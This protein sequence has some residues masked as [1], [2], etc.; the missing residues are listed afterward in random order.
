MVSP[1]LLALGVIVPTLVVTRGVRHITR[2]IED[3]TKAAQAMAQGEF[4]QKIVART[5]DEIEALAGQFNLMAA[6]IQ[7]SYGTLEQRVA[8]R[9]NEL[10]ALTKQFAILNAISAS[11]NE[12]LDLEET[13]NRVLD[14]TMGLLN[15]EVGEIRLLD[16]ESDELI[17]GAQRGMSPE[18][19]RRAERQPVTDILPSAAANQPIIIED[20]L[21]HPAY[22]LPR[23]EGLR[24]LAIFPLRARERLLGVLCL[25]TRRGPRP[26]A[27]SERELLRS[28]SDQA[29]VAIENAQLYVETRRR[30]DEIET[31]FAVQQA[32]TSRLDP[33]SVLQLIADEARRLTLA[34]GAFVFMLERDELCL[35]VISGEQAFDIAV[36]FRMPM[37]QSVTGVAL[38]SGQILRLA[39][40][41]QDPRTNQDLVRR[42]KAHSLVIVPLVSGPRIIGSISVVNKTTGPFTGD[43]ERVLSMLASSAI[44]GLENARLYQEEQDRRYEAEQRRQ[45]AEGLRDILTVLNSSRPLNEIL[46]YIVAQGTRLLGSEAVALFR[47]QDKNGGVLKPQAVLGLPPEYLTLVEIPVGEAIVG[48]VVQQIKPLAVPDIT[49]IPPVGTDSLQQDPEQWPLLAETTSRFRAMLGVPLVIKNEVYG[50]IML[51]YTQP[52][53]FTDEEIGLAVSFADQVA[54][55]I[56]NARLFDQAEQ[57]AILEERQ[58]LA[59]EL[60]DSVTQALYGVTMFAEAAARLLGAGKIELATDH[61]N[62]LRGTAQEA[63]QEMRLLLFELRPPVLEE[64]GLIAA[65]QTRLEAVERRSGLATELT[66]EGDEELPVPPKIEE[67][68]YRIAQEALNNALKHAQARRISIYLNLDPQKITLEIADDGQGFDPVKVRDHGGLGL[69]GMAERV[70]QLGACLT[71]SSQPGQG[72]KIKVEVQ[73]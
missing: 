35:S 62:E 28:V 4:N 21:T 32:I 59:R 26:V 5:G 57:A 20:L 73:P 15:L 30:V 1:L 12:S 13:L 65:L 54:L 27:R 55:A 11:V 53:E 39:D 68:L 8:A 24:A 46:D 7:E 9:T 6:Q 70:N 42:L 14:E 2:P 63:L 16:E 56:E 18:F 72:A 38:Q 29:S 41:G 10:A 22:S 40:A 43:D 69:Q 71:L 60:H 19:M 49:K 64:E 51:Y 45:V 31:L 61:L 66:V 58:R 23:E 17:I 34:G 33:Q 37:N 52:R 25:A 36:G 67:G 48:R 47:L 3:L 50:G 44:I